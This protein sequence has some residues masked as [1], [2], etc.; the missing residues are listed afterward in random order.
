MSFGPQIPFPRLEL[1][2]EVWG[3][4]AGSD[5]FA[6]RQVQKGMR[7]FAPPVLPP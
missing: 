3:V 2:W 1:N 7:V 6:A 4:M 5:L